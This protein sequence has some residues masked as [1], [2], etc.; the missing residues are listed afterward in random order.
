MRTP[1]QMERHIERLKDQIK[2]LEKNIRER[3]ASTGTEINRLNK[4]CATLEV[5][6][7]KAEQRERCADHEARKW[8]ALYE[9]AATTLKSLGHD[10]PQF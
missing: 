9:A 6:K 1:V 8:K 5:E 7:D 4:K 10:A 3:T 2:A